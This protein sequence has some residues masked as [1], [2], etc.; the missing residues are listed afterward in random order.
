M[1][2]AIAVFALSVLSFIHSSSFGE[3]LETPVMGLYSTTNVA[4]REVAWSTQ[5]GIRYVLEE[6]ANLSSNNWVAV[7][8]YPSKA[9]ALAQQHVVTLGGEEKFYRVRALDEQAPEIV[10]RTPEDDAFGVPRFSPIQ[11][12]LDDSS[13]VASNT[14]SLVVGTNDVFDLSDSELSWSTNTLVFDFGGDFA[15]GGYG[16][17]VDVS[18]A[19]ADVNGFSTNYTWQFELEKEVVED[20]DL[21]VFG[22]PTALRVGQQ[23]DGEAAVL[24]ARHRTGPVRMNSVSTAWEISSVETNSIIISYTS[25][26]APAFVA[27]QSLANLAPA[28]IDEIFYR[29]IESITTNQAAEELTIT[30]VDV[31][32]ADIMTDGS[33]TIGDDAIFLEFDENGYLVKSLSGDA[34]FELPTI[35]SDFSGETLFV[36][37][38]LDI[39]MEEAKFL[40][41]PK[42]KVSLETSWASLKRLEVEASGDLEIACVPVV[43]LSG[44]W[45]GEYSKELWSWRQFVQAGYVYVDLTATITA[46]ASAS[47]EATATMR[48]GFRQNANMGVKGVYL[49][50]ADPA[51]DWDRW[52]DVEP[53]EKIPFTYTLD[54]AGAAT[55][56]LVPQIDAKVVSLAGVY[57]NTDPRLEVEGAVST[58]N[59]EVI[60]ADWKFGAYADINAGLSVIGTPI[61]SLPSLP[62]FRIFTK[63]W[64][65][66]YE[67]EPELSP[68][69]IT[70]QPKSQTIK[71]GDPVVFSVEATS[72]SSI[73][74]QWYHNKKLIPGKT[75]RRMSFSSVGD[76]HAG[77][78]KVRVSAGG[79]SAFSEEAT[80]TVSD[81]NESGPTVSGYALLND[82]SIS[83]WNMGIGYD[84]F[85]FDS[86]YT[87]P[88]HCKVVAVNGYV[89]LRLMG[90]S[91]S[92]FIL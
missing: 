20:G 65:Y 5:P 19:V 55:V 24:A 59:D 51:V 36:D 50:D 77:E 41:H 72:S 69:V 74:Y 28:H 2:N 26:T 58:V 18:L 90:R 76:G 23:L 44:A 13:G 42:L 40:F 33:F 68:P 82:S 88:P 85:V 45:S 11:I 62:P 83:L 63:E 81:D 22:S 86:Y 17:T 34:T 61:G 4:Q 57:I 25:S 80:L 60:T 27:G 8:G 21:F 46:E 9:Q 78:Y 52:F 91:H 6:C 14:I 3:R 16:A 47:V 66:H 54:G 48:T 56:A 79:Q 53:F 73:S 67:K 49:K 29:K 71:Y 43:T 37:G 64:D 38:P 10:S 70:V 15:L 7:A 30:T 84:G 32:L 35:G 31:T 89:V 92:I 87:N 12:V 75:S 39:T 1:R